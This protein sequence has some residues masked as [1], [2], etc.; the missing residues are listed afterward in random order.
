MA[1]RKRR[2][3]QAEPAATSE[4]SPVR[5]MGRW[6]AAIVGAIATIL[7]VALN[8]D[9]VGNL[10]TDRGQQRTT[11]TQGLATV[12]QQLTERKYDLAWNGIEKAAEQRETQ[13]WKLRGLPTLDDVHAK[14]AD[15]AMAW[16]R[17]IRLLG[18]DKTFTAVVERLEPSLQREEVGTSGTR[19]ADVIAHL[20]YADFLRTRDGHG[21]L[22]PAA[23]YDEAIRIDPNNPYAVAMLAHWRLWNGG[24][25]ADSEKLFDRALATKRDVAFVRKLQLSA[26]H[27]RSDDDG[28]F[29]FLRTLNDMRISGEPIGDQ[30]LS[31]AAAIYYFHN[32]P[33]EVTA[34]L[35][36]MP[37][38]DHLAL[39]RF[40]T[41]NERVD[42]KRQRY[43]YFTALL[44]DATGDRSAARAD[45][46]A[47]QK[48]LPKDS[49]YRDD[50][51]SALHR[52]GA[53]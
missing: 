18:E 22:D 27:N 9:S 20:G 24:S 8:I 17:D 25:V 52:L 46:L 10:V 4:T 53:N 29:A 15:V 30:S 32:R 34:L 12:D 39:L 45:L 42:Y 14:E 43:M 26:L 38:Q 47:L 41:S 33:D 5:K 50:V 7:G 37:P 31:D 19:K 40:L 48:E 2:N 6:V 44:K 21:D 36:A 11:Y 16:L 3:Q 13:G 51:D 49:T 1:N 28:N 23:R 35:H